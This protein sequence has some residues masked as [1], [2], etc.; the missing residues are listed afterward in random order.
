MTN[1]YPEDDALQ[2]DSSPRAIALNDE[3]ALVQQAREVANP[4]PR[5]A[6]LFALRL[7]PGPRPNEHGRREDR[8]DFLQSI[9]TQLRS[10]GSVA[11]RSLGDVVF[12]TLVDAEPSVG[13]VEAERLWN[14][15]VLDEASATR[16]GV[17]D[18]WLQQDEVAF[19]FRGYYLANGDDGP[20]RVC[21]MHINRT[22]AAALTFAEC[23][24]P[25]PGDPPGAAPTT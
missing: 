7:S 4:L 16:V 24:I 15:V 6:A 8:Q 12:L 19:V 25:L 5:H 2:D 20:H 3:S 10:L 22:G 14:K 1:R 13:D 18:R 11:R 21:A 17:G 23:L 9:E